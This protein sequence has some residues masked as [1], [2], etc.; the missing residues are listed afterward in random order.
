MAVRYC[1]IA[2]CQAVM[3][4]CD[5][6]LVLSL[7]YLGTLRELDGRCVT[8]DSK[9]ESRAEEF[10]PRY[11]R[12]KRRGN[13]GDT[14]TTGFTQCPCPSSF[15]CQQCNNRR[16]T[17]RGQTIQKAQNTCPPG[18]PRRFAPRNDELPFDFCDHSKL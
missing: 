18:L 14:D 11:C 3:N 17:W 15:L 4:G 13:Q 12:C 1:C 2:D 8:S 5:R 16:E 7:I 10:A 9:R 6:L